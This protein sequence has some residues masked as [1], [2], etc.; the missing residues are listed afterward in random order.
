LLDELLAENDLSPA[1]A[2][3]LESWRH[4]HPMY[5]VVDAASFVGPED[6]ELSNELV[7]RVLGTQEDVTVL[8]PSAVGSLQQGDLLLARVVPLDDIRTI[9]GPVLHFHAS[10][11]PRVKRHLDEERALLEHWNGAKMSWHDISA[12]YAERLYAIAY[13]A[14]RGFPD[15]L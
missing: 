2:Q 13:R 4:C 14:T 6:V 8:S 3:Q 11:A 1:D 9:V 5:Y 10:M 12:R 15:E 7:L